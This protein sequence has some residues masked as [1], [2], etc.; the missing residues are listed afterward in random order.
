VNIGTLQAGI[1]LKRY[2]RFFVDVQLP[3]GQVVTAHC[4]NTGSMKGLLHPGTTAYIRSVNDPSRKLQ[5][6][7]ELLQTPQNHM[8]CVNTMRTN[9]LARQAILDHI[10]PSIPAA[11]Y[12]CSEVP[13][14]QENSRIDLFIPGSCPTHNTWTSAQE[15]KTYL[16][17]HPVPPQSWFIEVK[18]V[19][20]IE[21]QSTACFPDAVTTRGSKH[22]RELLHMHGQGHHAVLL[23]IV[24]HEQGTHFTP[25]YHID[26]SYS[27][28]L[29][30]A[31]QNGLQVLC[32][33]SEFNQQGQEWCVQVTHK[34]PVQLAP[35]AI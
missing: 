29:Y 11:A 19:T 22:I 15:V 5:Y 26:H 4:A 9:A 1:L 31:H 21:G 25:A 16:K 3:N 10:I 23:F 12:I 33:G 17:K 7:L 28:A 14:G 30:Q 2:K 34:I 27:Q 24:N 6:S 32:Y 13:Y 35:K 18:N 8:V 20:L